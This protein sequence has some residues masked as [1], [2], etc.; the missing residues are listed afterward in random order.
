[1]RASLEKGSVSARTEPETASTALM[2]GPTP[3]S[4]RETNPTVRPSGLQVR[5][6]GVYGSS[7]WGAL[8]E[9]IAPDPVPGWVITGGDSA[10]RMPVLS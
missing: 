5:L 9:R 2:L 1:M 4:R 3:L 10:I 7:A 8:S 6:L